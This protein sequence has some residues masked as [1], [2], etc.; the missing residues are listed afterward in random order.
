MTRQ[1]ILAIDDS[2][3]H[4]EI[5]RYSLSSERFEVVLAQDAAAGLRQA[6]ALTP[7]L[8]LLDVMMPEMDGFEVLK[9]LKESPSTSEIPVMMLTAVTREPDIS[10]GKELGAIE[11]VKKPFNALQLAAQIEDILDGR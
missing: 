1:K 8:I 4:L 11:Y 5:I 2:F 3:L 10:R 7:D 9:R 6:E